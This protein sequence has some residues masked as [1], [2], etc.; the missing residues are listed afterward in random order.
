MS[1]D[2]NSPKLSDDQLKA[3][4]VLMEVY[5]PHDMN[6]LLNAVLLKADFGECEPD[7]QDLVLALK[8]WTECMVLAED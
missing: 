6:R 5:T 3:T 2:Q 8:L 7:E 4:V 1:D